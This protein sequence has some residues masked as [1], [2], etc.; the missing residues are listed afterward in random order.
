MAGMKEP[1]PRLVQMTSLG[2]GAA[3]ASQAVRSWCSMEFDATAC[4]AARFFVHPS[5]M[6]HYTVMMSQR[7]VSGLYNG[8][9]TIEDHL[10]IQ[11]RREMS[12]LGIPTPP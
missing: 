2:S 12:I 6:A 11:P 9:Q 4:T 3:S 5:E 10:T 8:S 1:Y 7:E